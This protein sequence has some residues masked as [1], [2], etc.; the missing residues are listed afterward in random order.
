MNEL[1][2]VFDELNF[3]YEIM[4][5][6]PKANNFVVEHFTGDYKDFEEKINEHLECGFEIV[7]KKENEVL[8]KKNNTEVIIKIQGDKNV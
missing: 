6:L 7:D 2:E 8:L 4:V 5:I 1:Y 3:E